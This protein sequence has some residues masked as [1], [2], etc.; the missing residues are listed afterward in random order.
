MAGVGTLEVGG[1]DRGIGAIGR[2][3]SIE[4]QYDSE[5]ILLPIILTLRGISRY[6][7]HPSEILRKTLIQPNDIKKG[8]VC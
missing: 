8:T 2:W 7:N 6:H 5:S 3:Y 4:D 1:G